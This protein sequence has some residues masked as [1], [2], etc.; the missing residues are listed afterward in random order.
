MRTF[1]KRFL[2]FLLLLTFCAGG[3]AP[4]SAPS[5]TPGRGA[6]T[7]EIIPNPIVATRVSGDT[8]DFPFEVVIREIGGRPVD[9]S[10]VSAEVIAL[11]SLK[12][13]EESYDAARISALG[14]VTRV[15]ANGE[16]RYRFAPRRSADERLFSGVSADIRVE[17]R[18]AAGNDAFA[19]T[20][21]TVRR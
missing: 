10:R 20:S 8:Y 12:I 9:I 15:P 3:G 16:L 19:R 13:A 4:S 17:G 7:I 1:M 5:V 14:F 2:P 18:D 6:L 11:G 21:V